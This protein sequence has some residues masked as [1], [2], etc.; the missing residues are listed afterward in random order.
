VA[1]KRDPHLEMDFTD[2][3]PSALVCDWFYVFFIIYVVMT[4]LTVLGI[5]YMLFFTS[6]IFKTVFSMRFFTALLGL[7]FSGTNTLFFYIICKRSL[8]PQGA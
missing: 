2:Q 4:I 3:I 5:L 8:K 1:K 6:S 7:V